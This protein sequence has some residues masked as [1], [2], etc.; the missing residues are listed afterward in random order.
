MENQALTG[1]QILQH[2]AAEYDKKCDLESLFLYKLLDDASA[3]YIADRI[4]AIVSNSNEFDGL[5]IIFCRLGD[6][7][8]NDSYVARFDE[9]YDED[10]NELVTEEYKPNSLVLA[11]NLPLFLEENPE[12]IRPVLYHFIDI[13]NSVLQDNGIIEDY[14]IDNNT[15]DE[16]KNDNF[17]CQE[18]FCWFLG[19]A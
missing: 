8:G 1:S 17:N 7:G 12:I 2:F 14:Y 11:L 15:E 18:T 6:E 19:K 4:N 13:L 5:E 16:E 3:N 10:G 9:C